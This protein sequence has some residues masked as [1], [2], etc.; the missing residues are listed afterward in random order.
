MDSC[1]VADH[2]MANHLWSDSQAIQSTAIAV[3]GRLNGLLLSMLP[4]LKWTKRSLRPTATSA[5]SVEMKDN[6]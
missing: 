6:V 4:L 1:A 5:D 2:F 3:R